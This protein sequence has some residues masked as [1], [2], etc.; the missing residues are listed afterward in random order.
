MLL[1]A[2]SDHD[3]SVL[4]VDS[5]LLTISVAG[6][7]FG[8]TGKFSPFSGKNMSISGPYQLF[9]KDPSYRLSTKLTEK[10]FRLK[11]GGRRSKSPMTRSEL[12]TNS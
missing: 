4:M 7:L 5:T 8:V 6:I 2:V 1:S 11:P 9:N 3:S 10:L 12:S